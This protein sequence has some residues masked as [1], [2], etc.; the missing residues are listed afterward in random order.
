M[1]EGERE[2][3]KATRRGFLAV[4]AATAAAALAAAFGIRN[5]NETSPAPPAD[6]SSAVPPEVVSSSE[7]ETN[8]HARVEDILGPNFVSAEITQ[9]ENSTTVPQLP[10]LGAGF[11]VESHAVGFPVSKPDQE[12]PYFWYKGSRGDLDLAGGTIIAQAGGVT[13]I[14]NPEKILGFGANVLCR[15]E[16]YSDQNGRSLLGFLIDNAAFIS[17]ERGNRDTSKSFLMDTTTV[18]ISTPQ[19][20]VARTFRKPEGTGQPVDLILIPL[21]FDPNLPANIN[22]GNVIKGLNYQDIIKTEVSLSG[23]GKTLTFDFN[24]K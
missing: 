16:V 9:A 10:R 12:G 8:R 19:G 13:V 1:A 5:H 24:K 4:T 11:F 23:N 15:A 22:S 18:K 14:D 2:E 20:E 21:G 17:D 6:P 7:L 3:S